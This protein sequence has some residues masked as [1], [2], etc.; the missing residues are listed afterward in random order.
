[1]EE[2]IPPPG[3]GGGRRRA[4]NRD[5]ERLRTEAA[6]AAAAAASQQDLKRHSSGTRTGGRGGA[7]PE[8][9]ERL[10]PPFA[11]E[12]TRLLCSLA[13]QITLGCYNTSR[14]L[15][16]CYKQQHH[17]HSQ[18]PIKRNIT[19]LVDFHLI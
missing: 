13:P 11:A 18:P 10:C 8:G 7:T 16:D 6:A 5:A 2:T 4:G 3:R 15:Y 14:L 9:P 12:W 17:N 19:V 1:M